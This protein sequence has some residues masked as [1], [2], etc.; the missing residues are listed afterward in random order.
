MPEIDEKFD[1]DLQKSEIKVKSV[2]KNEAQNKNKKCYWCLKKHPSRSS[3]NLHQNQ[4]SAP[5][6]SE[7]INFSLKKY[8]DQKLQI[9]TL[10]HSTLL[11]LL[12]IKILALAHFTKNPLNPNQQKYHLKWV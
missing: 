8:L 5:R 12:A 6:S 11:F 9:L 10:S 4:K 1:L 7:I 3:K 2:I